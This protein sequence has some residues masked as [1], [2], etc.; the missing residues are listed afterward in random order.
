MKTCA[1]INEDWNKYDKTVATAQLNN[2]GIIFLDE[3]NKPID[4]E[5]DLETLF[6]NYIN[7]DDAIKSRKYLSAK[8]VEYV[9]DFDDFSNSCNSIV[10]FDNAKTLYDVGYISLSGLLEKNELQQF[11]N[12][13]NFE[14]IGNDIYTDMSIQSEFTKYGFVMLI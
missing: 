9:E 3:F 5:F 10:Y 12:H 11:E 1:L 8:E 2:Y 4:N 14:G 13:I 6:D 7:K